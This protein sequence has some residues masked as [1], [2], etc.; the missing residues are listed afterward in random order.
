LAA[1]F[2]QTLR[3]AVGLRGS[4]AA[5]QTSKTAMLSNK[6]SNA[7]R[8]RFVSFRDDDG[9][10]RFRLIGGD[11]TELLCSVAYED[12]K[13]AGGVMRRLSAE[14]QVC[15]TDAGCEVMLGDAVAAQGEA[16]ADSVRVAL[17]Q[18]A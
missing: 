7:K 9:S 12:P 2:M 13:E 6:P 15:S 17:R 14:G 5:S 3:E 16:D 1:P 10:F 11:G 4:S 18:L 8:A